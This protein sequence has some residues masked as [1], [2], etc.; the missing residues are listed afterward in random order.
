M[1]DLTEIF[2]PTPIVGGQHV[3]LTAY[4]SLDHSKRVCEGYAAESG[5]PRKLKWK[6]DASGTW[7][8]QAHRGL[9]FTIVHR[10]LNGVE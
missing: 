1:N 3:I 7:V 6:K 2:I 5:H 10:I 8:A 9:R 4:T